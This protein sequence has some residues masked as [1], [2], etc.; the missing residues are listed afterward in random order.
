MP[1]WNVC[2][3]G[4]CDSLPN[5][6]LPSVTICYACSMH[7]LSSCAKPSDQGRVLRR[8]AVWKPTPANRQTG[9]QAKMAVL[10]GSRGAHRTRGKADELG[11][12]L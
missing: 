3:P 9:Q 4:V 12:Q 7:L 5:L 1:G 8:P 10:E 11:L 2:V 6:G